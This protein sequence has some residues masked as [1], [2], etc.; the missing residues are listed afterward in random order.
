M[1]SDALRL[2]SAASY[3]AAKHRD[4]RRKDAVAAPYIDHPIAVATTLAEV[5]A[6]TDADLLVAALLHDTVEDTIASLDE[7]EALFGREVRDLVAEVTDDVISQ[8]FKSS[9]EPLQWRLSRM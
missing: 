2:L 8:P 4:Q 5:R 9:K 3:A 7:I 1:S 6:V